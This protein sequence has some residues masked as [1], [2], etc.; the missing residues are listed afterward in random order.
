MYR[1][2][3]VAAPESA[4]PERGSS[5]DV[6][7][8]E[9]SIGRHDKN[10][11][12]LVSGNVSKKHCVLVVSDEKVKL[13]DQGSSNG[14]FVN[15]KLSAEKT[16]RPGDKISIGE[17]VLELSHLKP[18][19][20]LKIVSAPQFGQTDFGGSVSSGPSFGVPQP[21][22]MSAPMPV[23]PARE[24][25]PA[26]PLKKVA[27]YF[28]KIVINYFHQL[29]EQVEF[30]VLMGLILT[31]AATLQLILIVEP[32]LESHR[33]ILK[34]EIGKRATV[35]AQALGDRN[36]AAIAQNQL[37]QLDTGG[38][39]R[40]EAVRIALIVDGDRKIIAPAK[41]LG[42]AFSYTPEVAIFRSLKDRKGHLI[43]KGFTR[44]LPGDVIVAVEP[45]QKFD[46]TLARNI[47][48]AFSVVS[49]HAGS[50]RS[51]ALGMDMVYSNALLT[52]AIIYGIFFFLLY[53]ITF[54]P[55]EALEDRLERALRGEEV[56]IRSKV[57]F[58]EISPLEELIDSCLKRL[59]PP[60]SD[61]G[62][63]AAQDLSPSSI[64]LIQNSVVPGICLDTD[65]R[66]LEANDAFGEVTGDRADSIKGQILSD[67]GRD[68]PFNLFIKD[69]VSRALASGSFIE[70]CA[71]NDATYQ[72]QVLPFG[73]GLSSAHV[74]VLLVR[75]S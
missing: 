11:I 26:S 49:I 2:T 9:V 72:A 38:I 55:I 67:V 30:R 64:S 35:L 62:G 23:A 27:Y 29:N 17:Y 18:K 1:L 70:D 71:F 31:A 19:S 59:P 45:L 37:S 28:E 25:I 20:R 13:H 14:T 12:V 24:E 68:A 58:P 46:P 22:M 36:G 5:F 39:D 16:I 73:T 15:G 69:A 3:V 42:Q 4:Q 60:G 63:G 57:K 74:V 33:E 65:G 54:K 32:I 44:N 6:E 75:K 7:N 43:S 50:V 51:Y 40:L 53:R 48:V 41:L 66:V 52:I 34:Q 8:G 61:L 21:P 47:T 56:N 10:Q